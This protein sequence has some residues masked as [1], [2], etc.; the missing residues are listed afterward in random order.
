[1]CTLHTAFKLIVG[2][3]P[4]VADTASS[5]SLIVAGS[6]G[7]GQTDNGQTLMQ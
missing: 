5:E 3:Q 2:R 1:M 6:L 4:C 7:L